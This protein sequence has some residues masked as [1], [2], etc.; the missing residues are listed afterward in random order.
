MTGSARIVRGD[1]LALPLDDST[2]DLIV[3]SPPY[4]GLRSYRDGG[5]HYAGQIG[6]EATPAEFV[7]ALIA[8]T[9]EMVRVLKPSGSIWVNLGD[10]YMGKAPGPQGATGDRADRSSANEPAKAKRGERPRRARLEQFTRED[11]A[12]LA[13]VIDSDGSIGVHINKQPE[14]RAPSFV[15]WV[16][17]G[18]MRPE[19]VERAAEIVGA[20]KVMH[21]GRGV[22]NWSASAQQA[23]WVLERIHPWLLIKKRQAWAAIELARH[24]ED[25]NAKGSWR[26]LTDDDVAYRQRLREAVM[27]WN[28]GEP[29]DM[30]VPNPGTVPLPIYPLAPRDKS[31]ADIPHDYAA[32]CI[33]RLGLILRAEVIWS[34]PNGLPESVT[35]RVRRS[36]ET[37]FHFTKS[38]R[39]FSAVDEIREG[40]IA[41]GRQAGKNAL[42]GMQTIRPRGVS[43]PSEPNPLGKL[44][45]S[46]W[47]IA[48]QP[49]TVPAHLGVDHFAAFPM[50]WPR[51]IIRGWSPAGVCVECGEG[52]RPVSAR[53]EPYNP[54]QNRY[55]Q[56]A[57]PEPHGGS[58]D[59]TTLGWQRD[60]VIVGEACA[61]PEPTAATTPGVVLDPFG[62]TGTTALV[63]KV[64]GRHAVSVDMSADY[65]RLATWRTTDPDQIARA[66]QVD[67]PARQVEGQADLFDH[68][69]ETP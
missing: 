31:L 29:D 36:H 69:E 19:V 67:K 56:T 34:K 32:A 57:R 13:G 51:R 41:P 44:P 21:D 24:I 12:W 11:A 65:C 46:V 52:R 3:T 64:L 15:P 8:A 1:A 18:Q 7:D 54:H 42:S 10:R 33:G 58:R 55:V 60:T 43:D 17:I 35:D 66:M 5:E 40:H 53:G 37:W 62:G 50:E 4:H 16:R 25:R 68:L 30:P 38:P 20:G 61:C 45:G 27:A 6:S 59:A 14:G 47:T 2:V 23:R 22:W 49:L 9:R 28:Q 48:T 63:A 26:P 39:Y